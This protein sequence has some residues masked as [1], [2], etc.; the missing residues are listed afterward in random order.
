MALLLAAACHLLLG[1]TSL[2]RFHY[3]NQSLMKPRILAIAAL[4]ALSLLLAA[5]FLAQGPAPSQSSRPSA[6]AASAPAE[7]S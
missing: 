7:V 4:A 5:A 2:G 3:T 1:H 6:P